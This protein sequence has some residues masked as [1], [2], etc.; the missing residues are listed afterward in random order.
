[1][2]KLSNKHVLFI[3][4]I[5]F[6]FQTLNTL[7]CELSLSFLIIKIAHQGNKGWRSLPQRDQ[8]LTYQL[9]E[10]KSN[11]PP[12]SKSCSTAKIIISDGP[13]HKEI[14]SSSF[15][16]SI[17]TD[18]FPHPSLSS[19]SA[20]LYFPIEGPRRSCQAPEGTLPPTG[21]CWHCWL[22]RRLRAYPHRETPMPKHTP[23]EARTCPAV[24]RCMLPRV[25]NL[26][27]FQG[28]SRTF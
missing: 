26:I 15:S 17:F 1:M 5:N 9:N 22:D 3:F 6:N 21:S 19:P 24:R 23:G 7:K 25:F 14:S 20:S 4:V 10:A 8:K 13:I 2:C 12:Y 16:V 18:I 28:V 27:C 11:P